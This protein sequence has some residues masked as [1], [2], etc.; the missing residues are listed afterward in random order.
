MF[1]LK[2]R[3]EEERLLNEFEI[4]AVTLSYFMQSLF[5]SYSK[6]NMQLIHI[7]EHTHTQFSG[8]LKKL[9]SK[10]AGVQLNSN[11]SH[12]RSP[13]FLEAGADPGGI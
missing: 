11:F 1:T 6:T 10:C 8:Y 12:I 5:E 3:R 13:V 9:L 7:K 4:S 2:A